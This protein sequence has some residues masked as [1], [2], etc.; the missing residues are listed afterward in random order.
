MP[1]AVFIS[2]CCDVSV[3]PEI[4]LPAH[5]CTLSFAFKLAFVV[6]LIHWD[7]YTLSGH[8]LAVLDESCC[9]VRYNLLLLAVFPS[10]V[11]VIVLYCCPSVHVS[12]THLLVV[13]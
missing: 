2:C 13:S 3:V 12:A 11:Y 5:V 10:F 6:C 9:Y 1:F 7:M 4:G 8:L